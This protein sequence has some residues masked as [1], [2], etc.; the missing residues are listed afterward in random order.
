MSPDLAQMR[1]ADRIEQCLILEAKR[2]HLLSQSILPGR[3][4]Q[5]EFE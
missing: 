4:L 2:K 5:A 3:A 1:S